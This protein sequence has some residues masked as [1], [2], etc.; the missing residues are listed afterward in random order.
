MDQT[1]IEDLRRIAQPAA[2]DAFAA[3]AKTAA[4]TTAELYREHCEACHGPNGDGRGRAGRNLFPRPRD[5]RTGKSH[6]VRTRNGVP[7]LE[8]IEQV[9]KSGMGGTSMKAF[10]T[11][12]AADRRRLAEEVVRGQLRRSMAAEGETVDEAEL[13]AAVKNCTTPGEAVRMPKPWPDAAERS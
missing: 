2:L 4:G 13:S 3:P 8:D 9:L 11:L 7:T 12:S 10:D 1:G 5:L 6:I